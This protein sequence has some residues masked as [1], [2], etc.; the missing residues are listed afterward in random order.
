ML[1]STYKQIAQDYLDL[2]LSV[3]GASKKILKIDAYNE[4]YNQPIL[5]GIA[6]NLVGDV[7]CIDIDAAKV[8]ACSSYLTH[9]VQGDIRSLPY[10]NNFFDVVLD[11]STIDHIS[12]YNTALTEYNRVLKSGGTIINTFW[13]SETEM[14]NELKNQYYF[15]ITSYYSAL[16]ALFTEV[17]RY[18]IYQYTNTI[19]NC[20][21]G[22]KA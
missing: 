11:F 10:S 18:T 5:K 6:G 2:A 1:R 19:L 8:S 21:K 15:N 12:N 13:G 3:D 9:I 17:T 14:Y 16:N 4:Y 7:Y 20:Y 22:T